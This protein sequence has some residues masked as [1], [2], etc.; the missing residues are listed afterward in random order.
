[1]RSCL[2]FL[3]IV[4][5]Q[6]ASLQAF[7][8][9]QPLQ[10]EHLSTR[11]GLSERN[12]NCIF[13]DSRGFI[14]IGTRDGLN[15]YDGYRFVV[16]RNNPYDQTSISNNYI[17]HL[18]EDRSGNIWI[19]TVGG[20][21]NKFNPK[22][23]RFTHY[24]HQDNNAGSLASDFI[25]KIALDDN[26]S[27]WIATQSDGLDNFDPVAGHAV[28]YR[29]K[30]ADAQ[31]I[32]GNN[33]FTVYKDSRGNIWAGEQSAGL[34]LFNR[35]SKSFTRFIHREQLP[36]SISGNQITCITEDSDHRLWIGT[37]GSGLN[38]YIGQG[39]FK[40]LVND[41]SQKNSLANNSV[42]S[43]AEDSN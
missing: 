38:L 18:A 32:S 6:T 5:L 22:S 31:S 33:I 25:N 4:L 30:S 9:G 27:I 1:L 36:N 19:A 24:R 10:F 39:N 21:L 3:F 23:D 12:I 41:P 11:D 7:S 42:Q 13:Q 16:Y 28:H 34:N 29:N 40:H 17:S 35:R 2:K 8:Q 14:W 37:A 26:G 20:G 15:R 43:L